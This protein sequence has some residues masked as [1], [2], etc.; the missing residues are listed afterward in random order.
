MLDAGKIDAQRLSALAVLDWQHPHGDSQP[1]VASV[2]SRHTSGT[3]T[4]IQAKHPNTGNIKILGGG[5]GVETDNT[6]V[7]F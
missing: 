6:K 2:C 4:F 7:F 1:L 3:Q 5:R